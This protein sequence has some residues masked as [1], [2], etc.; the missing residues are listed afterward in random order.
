[1]GNDKVT[2]STEFKAR[3][4]DLINQGN[5][6]FLLNLSEVPFVDSSGLGA[7]ISILKT[8][9]QNNGEIVLCELNIPVLNLFKLTRMDSV[10][11]I[12]AS[13]REGLEAL[14]EIKKNFFEKNF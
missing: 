3:V 9:M 11:K 2:T 12:Y 7:L 4:A 14:T 10:F 1:V 5:N 13:E 8:L 6:F